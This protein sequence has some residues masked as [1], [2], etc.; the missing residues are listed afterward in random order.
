MKKT[1]KKRAFISAIA[2]LI[3]SAIVLT[4]STFAWFS[5]AKKAEVETMQLNITS[6]EGIQISANTS[7]WTTSLTEDDFKATSTTRFKA[8]DDNTNHFPEV[9]SPSSSAFRCQAAT[10]PTFFSGSIDESGKANAAKVTD[11]T[12]GYVV[13]DLFVKLGAAQNVYFGD[14]TITCADNADVPTAMRIAAVNCGYSTDKTTAK[15]VLEGIAR[16]G[17]TTSTGKPTITVYEVDSKNHTEASGYDDGTALTTQGVTVAY[18]G[19]TPQGTNNNVFTRDGVYTETLNCTQAT[20]ASKSSA[21]F[22]GNVG[23]NRIR[24]YIWMEGNDVD[25]ANDVAGSTIDVN[26]ILTI[27]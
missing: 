3:V 13:F 9:L 14:S 4:S 5:M 17:I 19:Q 11:A 20:D 18:T 27:S 1:I 24:V 12:G 22:Y 16:Y 25:C 6:P 2:M 10:L 26:L 8:D 7:A 15:T 21:Y 23:I